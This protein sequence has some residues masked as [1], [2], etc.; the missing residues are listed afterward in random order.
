MWAAAGACLVAPYLYSLKRIKLLLVCSAGVFLLT[1]CAFSAIFLLPPQ[2]MQ[3]A[4]LG[5]RIVQGVSG[6][7]FE[8]FFCSA[9]LTVHSERVGTVSGLIEVACDIGTL[10]APIIGAF[11]YEE[12]GFVTT[13]LIPCV[14]LAIMLLW[15]TQAP[16]FG[17]ETVP[18]AEEEAQGSGF[19]K[20]FTCFPLMFL[21]FLPF[22]TMAIMTLPMSFMAPFVHQ[23]YNLSARYT[24]YI[25]TVTGLAY[26]VTCPLIGYFSDMPGFNPFTAIL[27]CPIILLLSQGTM[28]ASHLLTIPLNYPQIL[29]AY[30]GVGFGCGIGNGPVLVAIFKAWTYNNV[31]LRDHSAFITSFFLL[32][33]PL[34][35][36]A[37]TSLGGILKENMSFMTIIQGQVMFLAVYS[38]LMIV[39]TLTYGR[40]I[41]QQGE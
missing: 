34:G 21:M 15:M 28:F 23:T 5:I 40:R 14:V 3:Y 20:I 36:A 30:A 25:F 8:N 18:H 4:A 27:L 31:G 10:M 41:Q 33:Y 29:V 13:Q 9:L 7:L 6:G 38:I 39:F 26:S 35:M 24:G 17:T 32:C 2:Y 12:F 1:S 37:G 22:S 16:G 11:L 19:S